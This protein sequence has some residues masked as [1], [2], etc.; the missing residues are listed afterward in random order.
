MTTI[1]MIE[2]YAKTIAP[3]ELACDWD[4]IGLLVGGADGA[5][6]RALLA[7]DITPAVVNEA[8]EL[9][10][11]L[12]ISHHPVIFEPLRALEPDT[13]PYLLA[14]YDIAA[15]CL[16]T[17]LDRAEQGVNTALAD[18]L[19]LKNIRFF[20]D[21]YLLTGEPCQPMAAKDFA[22]FVKERLDAP[23]VRF[24]D[25]TVTRVAVSSGGG[26]GGVELSG[27]YGFDAFVTG[28][29]KH[30]QYLYALEHGIAAFDAGHFCTENVIIRPLRSVLADRFPD[31]EFVV[32]KRCACPYRAV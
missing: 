15:L 31:V 3:Y 6:S 17:N 4:N 20:P 14:K 23:S 21:D 26:G 2:E 13:A 32:S 30:H 9:D 8:K 28:E 19:E 10:A 1:R 7:L 18:A 24:T 25:G 16:H 27:Q 5:V 12:I 11:Q 22:V 29:L